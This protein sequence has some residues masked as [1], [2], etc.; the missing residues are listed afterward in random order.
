MHAVL[1]ARSPARDLRRQISSVARRARYERI[2]DLPPETSSPQRSF[3]SVSRPQTR[4]S[5]GKEAPPHLSHSSTS[6]PRTLCRLPLLYIIA[7]PTLFRSKHQQQ[8]CIASDTPNNHHH[9][10]HHYYYRSSTVTTLVQKEKDLDKGSKGS[11]TNIGAI[12]GGVVGGLFGLALVGLLIWFGVRRRRKQIDIEQRSRALIN[13]DKATPVSPSPTPGITDAPLPAVPVDRDSVGGQGAP[14][15]PRPPP[16]MPPT[17]DEEVQVAPVELQSREVDPD[18]VS[19]RSFDM[20]R[21]NKPA[22]NEVPRLPIYGG[23]NQAL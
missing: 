7:A 12:I 15:P 19:V 1:I 8:A 2:H 21:G 5:S 4:E 20:E 18:G 23:G 9:H 10:H 6:Y 14:L 13:L 16:P 17:K 22:G 11:E 3:G